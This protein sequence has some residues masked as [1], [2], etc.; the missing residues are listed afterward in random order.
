M[1]VKANCHCGAVQIEMNE[2]PDALLECNCSVCGRYGVKWAYYT[3]DQVKIIADKDAFDFYIWGDRTTNFN[4]CKTCGC[5]T[6][7][8][9]AEGEESDRVAVNGRMLADRKLLD[10][11]PMRYF[12]GRDSWQMVDKLPVDHPD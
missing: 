9:A 8:T 11:L 7:Y 4:F 12:D 10:A 2:A 5:L 6:H 3:Q 1:T